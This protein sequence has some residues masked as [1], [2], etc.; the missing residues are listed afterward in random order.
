MASSYK[1]R[2][3]SALQLLAF[4]HGGT[5]TEI[6][7]KFGSDEVWRTFSIGFNNICCHCTDILTPFAVKAEVT[8]DNTSIR[9]SWEW[10]RHGVLMCVGFVRVYYQPEGGSLMRYTVNSTTATSAT[11]PN[12]QCDTKYTVWVHAYTRGG[13]TGKR[14]VSRIVSLPARGMYMLCNLPPCSVNCS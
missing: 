12:L 6:G 13:Q 8:A 11:L 1:F 4:Q 10:S 14:S 5:C 9:V 3:H 2:I 7:R